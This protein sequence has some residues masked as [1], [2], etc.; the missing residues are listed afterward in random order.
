M[1]LRL[2][3]WAVAAVMLGGCADYPPLYPDMDPKRLDEEVRI[4]QEMAFDRWMAD[5][6]HLH[7]FYAPLIAAAEPFCKTGM[8]FDY[9]WAY[10]NIFDWPLNWR[11][12]A[13]ER[14]QV[15]EHP[16]IEYVKPGGAAERA[17]IQPRDAI[18]A[19]G[20]RKIKPNRYAWDYLRRAIGKTRREDGGL[21]VDLRRDEAPFSVTV[22][23]DWV[24]DF[25]VVL[26]RDD[27]TN[28]Y[29]NGLGTY[30]TS[31]MMRF[32]R[33]D[34]ELAQVLT[35]EI[36]H[37]ILGHYRYNPGWKSTPAISQMLEVEAD[38]VGLYLLA[39]AGYDL[40]GAADLWRR[41]GAEHVESIKATSRSSHPTSPQRYLAISDTTRE[42]EGK[43]SVNEPLVPD[44]KARIN[45]YGWE[46]LGID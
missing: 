40:E 5:L 37:N 3:A 27:V 29:A 32:L 22:V 28:A 13:H 45:K 36:A 44:F 30:I 18:A 11:D 14:Y 19:I 2:G 6:E 41:M 42:I 43:R 10:G 26:L 20:G 15:D 21:V 12:L 34:R 24:C 38:Y 31:G 1:R 9:G 7:T 46:Y 16:R 25:P 39:R 8:G 4:Q 17:G 33:D 23:P 35:H